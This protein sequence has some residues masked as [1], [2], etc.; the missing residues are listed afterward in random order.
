M[1]NQKQTGKLPTKTQPKQKPHMT[2]Q[3]K[4]MENPQVLKK[5]WT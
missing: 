3:T 4:E 5:T 1:Y 2:L